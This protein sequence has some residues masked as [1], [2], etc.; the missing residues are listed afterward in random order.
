MDDGGKTLTTYRLTLVQI[1]LFE[2]MRILYMF[3]EIY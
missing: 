3:Q 2:N 1:S